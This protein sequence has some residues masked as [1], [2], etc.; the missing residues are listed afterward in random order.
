MRRYAFIDVPNTT[1]TAKSVLNFSIDWAKL[2]DLLVN[3]KWSCSSVFFY[4]GNK[5][6]K[7]R[8]QLEKIGQL[9]YIV[10]TKLTHI[11]PDWYKELQI[12]CPHCN[13]DFK[14]NELI[15]GN[16]KSNCDVELTVDALETLKEGDEAMLFTADGDF[17]YLIEKLLERKVGV[18]LVSS[19]NRDDAG[20]IRFSTRLTAMLER[21]EQG[22]KRV[23]F[24]HLNNWKKKIEKP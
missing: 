20:K 8:E 11:H 15:R 24:I 3:D 19:K 7:E 21:E 2:Y 4:R 22:Q 6:D 12:N 5:G 16:Q 18:R 14:Y 10:R 13:S 1:G 17:A 9:G 23:Q